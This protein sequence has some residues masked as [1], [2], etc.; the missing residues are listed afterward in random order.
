MIDCEV[1]LFEETLKVQTGS[2]HFPSMFQFCGTFLP[3]Y[4]FCWAFLNSPVTLC[5]ANTFHQYLLF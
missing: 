2:F 4:N 3:E 1:N 5:A